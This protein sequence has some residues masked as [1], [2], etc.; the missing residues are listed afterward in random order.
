LRR[1][2]LAWGSRHPAVATAVLCIVGQSLLVWLW[3]TMDAGSRSAYGEL[4]LSVVGSLLVGAGGIRVGFTPPRVRARVLGG[5]GFAALQI[6]CIAAALS[7]FPYL[8]PLLFSE[9]FF[10]YLACAVLA[11]SL[12]SGVILGLVCGTISVCV[13]RWVS[14]TLAATA[15]G[16][17][18]G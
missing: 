9:W 4:V 8:L 17:S 18:A 10:I 11:S 3:S 15:A 14:G 6:P 12:T 7:L 13:R 16:S 5:L 1:R 2:L